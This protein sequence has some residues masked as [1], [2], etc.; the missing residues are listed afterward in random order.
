M[1]HVAFS[2]LRANMARYFD[3]AE[4][5]RTELT[6]VRQGHEPMVIMPLS[7][8]EGLRETLYLLSSPENARR[9]FEAIAQLDA[10]EGVER[11]LSDE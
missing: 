8:L 10:G 6:V 4:A 3:Q 11:T 9:M 7:E 5:D 2:E 1:S